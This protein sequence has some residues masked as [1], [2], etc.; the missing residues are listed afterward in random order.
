[1]SARAKRDPVADART[2]LDAAILDLGQFVEAAGSDRGDDCPAWLF[3]A[4]R[5]HEAISAEFEVLCKAIRS[6]TYTSC[7]V[8]KAVGKAGQ[9]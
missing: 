7:T 8:E 9:L 2:R 5:H 1:V 3:C 6:T 4:M